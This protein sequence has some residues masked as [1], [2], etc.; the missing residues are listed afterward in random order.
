MAYV[1]QSIQRINLK[2]VFM[3][4]LFLSLL[5]IGSCLYAFSSAAAAEQQPP[6]II[7]IV[8]D[9][10]GYGDLG[11]Y[12]NSLVRTPHIDRLAAG[13]L[14]FTDFHSAGAMCTPTRAAMLTGQYQQRFGRHL[15]GALSGKHDRETGLPLQAVTIAE[16]L[17]QQGYATACFGKWHLGYQPPWLPTSQGFDVFR[18]L[19]SGDGD[20]HTHINRSGN[21]DWWKNNAIKMEE[22]Y[23]ADLLTKY[24]LEFME[25]NRGQPFFL[26]VPHLA[27]HFPWQ[28]PE[29]PPHRVAGKSYHTDKWGIIPDPGNVRPHTTAMI[30]SLDQSVGDILAA[31]RRMQLEKNTIV[32]FT[33]DNGG[34]LNYGKN[35][36]KI[37]SN[38]RLRGQK[39]TLY[40]GGHRVPLL[41][42]WPG[43]ITAG[44]TD[45][46][47]HSVDLLPTL[48]LAAGLQRADFKTDGL[49]LS[50][51]WQSGHTLPSRNLYW[52]MGDNR[53]VRSGHWKLCSKNG[54][55]ELYD[56]KTDL[57]EQQNLASE[58]PDIVKKLSHALKEWEEDVDTSAKP[59]N[60]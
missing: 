5:T 59:F 52:R 6:N 50:S 17:K 12:G 32:I 25:A 16:L 21:R 20:H 39:G 10:L 22:G 38:G 18:G 28:G 29:D 33:S 48:A 47:A 2:K 23:T 3:Q 13:G 27:I 36:Q 26:Y 51:L 49:D 53:A 4:H 44:V 11:C 35:F 43:T 24:S 15:E 19:A 31:V 57:G 37:S 9:D 46:T 7:L 55:S 8:A 56:L 1:P 42:A 40:E 14:K 58:R 45:Q 34:Y 54:G 60:K 41:I 30:E